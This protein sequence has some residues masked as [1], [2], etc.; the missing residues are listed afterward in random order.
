[1]SVPEPRQTRGRAGVGKRPERSPKHQAD[2]TPSPDKTPRTPSVPL[3]STRGGAH[4]NFD[5]EIDAGRTP[6]ASANPLHSISSLSKPRHD[7]QSPSSPR[8]SKSQSRSRSRSLV[9]R[10]PFSLSRPKSPSKQDIDLQLSNIAVNWLAFNIKG[11]EILDETQALLKDVRRI[12]K[13]FQVIP[14]VIKRRAM[15]HMIKE[16]DY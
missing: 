7:S 8:D 3:R 15:K 16:D 12:G 14:D 2:A 5:A 4:P 1:M 10:A 13:G 11:L 6:R 9:S